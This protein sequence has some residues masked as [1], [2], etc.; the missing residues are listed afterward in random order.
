MSAD[1]KMP[2]PHRL[3]IV[4]AGLTGSVTA[5]LLRRKFPKGALNI[6]FWEEISRSRGEN[7][8]QQKRK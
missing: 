2:S 6:T 4:G 7:E 8:Y 1:N 5:S 3:L